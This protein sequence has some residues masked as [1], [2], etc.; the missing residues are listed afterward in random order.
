[1]FM[2]VN[3]TPPHKALSLWEVFEIYRDIADVFLL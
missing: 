3:F 2:Y 1:M